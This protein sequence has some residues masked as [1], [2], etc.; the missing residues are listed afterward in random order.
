MGMA[1]FSG[2]LIA[3]VLGVL[4]VPG[5][6]IMIEGIGKAK[7]HKEPVANNDNNTHP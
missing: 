2:M 4:I 6:Y 3:T 7:D 5:L 1:V